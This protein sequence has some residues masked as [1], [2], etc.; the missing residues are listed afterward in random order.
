M[1]EII[2]ELKIEVSKPNIFQAVVAKQYDMNTRFI[3]ATF[4]DGSDIISIPAVPTVK[5]IINAER[6][7]GQ[8]QG[9][10]GVI[11]DDGTVTV[12]LHS[13]MLE[14]DGTVICDISTIDTTEGNNK[15]LTT[16]AFTLL[17]EKA[18]YGGDEISSDPQYDILIEL[19]NSCSMAE[20]TAQEALDKSNEAL[21]RSASADEKYDACVEATANANNVLQDIQA[22][23]YIESLKEINNGAKF[24]VW[25]GTQAE[26]AALTET[27]SNCLYI[28]TDDVVPNKVLYEAQSDEISYDNNNFIVLDGDAILVLENK[29]EFLNYSN[30]I[31][32]LDYFVCEPRYK[33]WTTCSTSLILQKTYNADMESY[34]Y[35]GSFVRETYDE[36]NKTTCAATMVIG[37]D[38][39]EYLDDPE[40]N[41]D[42]YY[43]NNKGNYVID[44]LGQTESAFLLKRIIGL[45]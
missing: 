43:L 37:A 1:I 39:T 24:C 25:I 8:S 29:S 33:G 15:K 30:L 14:L 9:F 17:V 28:V 26:K 40:L 13:W 4:V 31:L 5:A 19:L 35:T 41:L 12:P 21:A 3:K 36:E 45:S 27:R 22:G 44:P 23:G 20:E 10:E 11:N 2:K 6:P 16:T 34:E 32:E 42:F 38:T 18:S 7:D